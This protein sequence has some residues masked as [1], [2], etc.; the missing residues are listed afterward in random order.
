MERLQK[1]IAN[2]GYTSRRNAEKL[3][4]ENKVLVNGELINTLGYKVSGNDVIEVEGTILNKDIKKEYYL[5]NKPREVIS[6]VTDDKGRM[7]VIDFIPTETRIYPVGR[8]DYDTTGLIILTN[9]G[10]LSN[11]LMHPKG[12]IS[13][14]YIAKINGILNEDDFKKIR[15]GI[16]IDN[17]VLKVDNI[18]VR[19]IDKIK[20]TSLVEVTIHEGRNHIIRKLFESLHYDVKKLNRS[21]YAF[22][23][24]DG[25]KSGEFRELSLKEVKKL[26]SLKK[27]ND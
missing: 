11:I 17:K 27:G 6:S 25:L 14:T 10:E 12:N 3:I 24:C 4:L 18:K 7:T 20:N 15:Q 5:L 22:L 13:K 26:Y 21:K 23:T 1:V 9:D 2:S 16:K 8:L 19:K